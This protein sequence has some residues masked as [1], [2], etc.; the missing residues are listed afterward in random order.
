[1]ISDL[2]NG[3]KKEILLVIRHRNAL[4]LVF[5]FP[6]ITIGA[7]GGL[8]SYNLNQSLS[9]AV[10][11]DPAIK[12]ISL[13]EAKNEFNYNVDFA[14]ELK[15][16]KNL[17]VHELNS[18]EEL[19]Q[20]VLDN[21]VDSGLVIKKPDS[22]TPYQ[23]IV[24][25][26]TTDFVQSSVVWGTLSNEINTI[27]TNISISIIQKI[28]EKIVSQEHRTNQQ[29]QRINSFIA[30]FE[31]T[32]RLTQELKE[33]ANSFDVNEVK[34][35][36]QQQ[37]T[38]LKNIREDVYVSEFYYDSLISN[39]QKFPGFF[40]QTIIDQGLITRDANGTY[41]YST[42]AANLEAIVNNYWIQQTR[43]AEL[44]KNR[45]VKVR[46]TLD[47]SIGQIE[48]LEQKLDDSDIEKLQSFVSDA[49]EIQ[50]KVE[51][52]L[53]E[54]RSLLLEVNNTIQSIKQYSPQFLARPAQLEYGEAIHL[55]NL[56]TQFFPMVLAL[57]IMF[58]ALLL[59]AISIISEKK[60][61]VSNRLKSMPVHKSILVMQKLL[62]I[63]L[64]LVIV[65]SILILAGSMFGIQLAGNP[66]QILLSLSLVIVC[67]VSI[68]IVIGS[69]TNNEPSAILATLVIVF[70]M[71]FLSGLLLPLELMPQGFQ[72]FKV[73]NPLATSAT[74]LVNTTIKNIPLLYSIKEILN[75][76]IISF[77]GIIMGYLKYL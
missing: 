32:K 69:L 4:F 54:S 70:P 64:I 45:M 35:T 9:I 24:V 2:L 41:L 15:K 52:D 3:I 11:V 26:D 61:N 13:S 29:L 55:P 19:R 65:L 63:S 51:S 44:Q 16:N 42:G 8:Y 77:I 58:S 39:T 49:I 60:Q 17:L 38:E 12:Q 21:T 7:F 1:M 47:I 68:G 50:N 34:E 59:T 73:I 22:K 23:I 37:K 62:G 75:L 10:F 6:L 30:D 20:K 36:L 74:L 46:E 40:H 31:K 33:K 5:L 72:I 28:Y 25:V 53:L 57:V 67:F 27:T 66:I 43:D 56:A 71:I 18:E 14:Q 76:A 48:N